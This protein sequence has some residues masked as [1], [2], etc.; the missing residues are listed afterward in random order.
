MKANPLIKLRLSRRG[1][2]LL[3]LGTLMGSNFIVLQVQAAGV[4]GTG[5]PASCTES[6]FNTAL[7]GG[8]SVRFNCG[9][10][11]TITV[12]NLKQI[13]VDTTIDGDGLITLSGSN[14][15]FF[16]VFFANPLTLR[17]I[18]LANGS[19]S[20]AGAIENFGTTTIIKSQLVNNHSLINAGAIVNYGH[21][22]LTDSTLSN[23]QAVNDGGV[24]YNDG[25]TVEATGSL[26]ADNK[27]TGPTGK[28]GAIANNAG[29][30]SLNRV[31]LTNNSAIGTGGGIYNV[32]SATLTNVTLSGNSADRYGGGVINYG[33]TA[34]LTL[35]NVTL[36][37]NKAASNGGGI[38]HS[39][40]ASSETLALKNSIV[41]NSPTGGNCFQ[42]STSVTNI[43]SSGFNLSSDNSCASY[44]NQPG[45]Q[46]NKPAQLGPLASNG[47]FTLTHLPLPPIAG[48]TGPIDNGSCPAG[49]FDQRGVSR[50]QGLAC[51][52][53]AV[54]Y[55]QGE[56][57]PW[58]Y[59][60]LIKR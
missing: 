52:I 58:L 51:D 8:G 18:T 37:G 24:I 27:V 38:Y 54:E 53:G 35:T 42:G 28:G 30:I 57:T 46:N 59:L 4:V 50:P 12:T 29:S 1:L 32:N 25:G 15:Y 34:T 16:Q 14:T 47:G 48:G 22:V 2:I 7:T 43:T 33:G 3:L 13:S 49:S 45:D 31:A 17:N 9:G 26:F 39:G 55:R 44:F 20:I 60:P 6:A 21:L 56:L 40:N 41:A 36:S 5:T 11:A 10:L 23:N 19:S